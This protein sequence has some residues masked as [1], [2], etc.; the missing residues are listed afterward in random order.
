MCEG[1]LGAARRIK[2]LRSL[3]HQLQRDGEDER[4]AH[5]T[6]ATNFTA[7]FP[8]TKCKDFIILL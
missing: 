3:S 4:S 2:E 7:T 8:K 5:W 1:K 6:F